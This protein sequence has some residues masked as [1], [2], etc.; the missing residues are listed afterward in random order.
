MQLLAVVGDVAKD[1]DTRVQHR[2]NVDGRRSDLQLYA[3]SC[4]NS[5]T[6][7][8]TWVNS[9]NG[10]ITNK[11]PYHH[12]DERKRWPSEATIISELYLQNPLPS[13]LLH[14]LRPRLFHALDHAEQLRL[15]R[16]GHRDDRQ[17]EHTDQSINQS[18]I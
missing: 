17:T 5:K 11:H 16:K 15:T 6:P 1:S 4:S 3:P 14:I 9:G 2:T 10:R 7:L 8:E 12:I 18:I 13:H